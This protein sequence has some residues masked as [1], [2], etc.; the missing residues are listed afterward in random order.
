MYV[1]WR[2][3]IPTK[4]WHGGGKKV[5]VPRGSGVVDRPTKCAG[6]RVVMVSLHGDQ[7]KMSDYLTLCEEGN[8]IFCS[9]F[10]VMLGYRDNC[11]RQNSRETI[12]QDG[13]R[14]LRKLPRQL[15]DIGRCPA[16]DF[17]NAAPAKI[18]RLGTRPRVFTGQPGQPGHWEG[19][20]E[21]PPEHQ[22]RRP[23]AGIPM[24]RG[25]LW[26]S[27]RGLTPL[28]PSER[29]G[30]PVRRGIFFFPASSNVTSPSAIGRR[31]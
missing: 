9:W 12:K 2:F 3:D 11:C 30:P 1:G 31:R 7:P 29:A 25:P 26:G 4:R 8:V 22:S 21:P 17:L 27:G 5:V 15:A 13:M 28:T 20:W 6:V 24:S 18:A 10:R 23:A 19:H 14:A 16:T